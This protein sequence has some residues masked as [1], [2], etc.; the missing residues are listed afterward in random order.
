MKK[1]YLCNPKNIGMSKNLVIVESPA[2]AKTIE[3]FLGK[4]YHVLSC[5]GHI[6]DLPKNSISI[7][8][9]R[10]FKPEYV[11]PAEKKALISQ[12]SKAAKAAD[13]VWLASDEDREGEAIAWH[14]DQVL[15]L[16]PSKT[17]RIVFNEITKTAILHAIENPREL[18]YDLVDAQQARRVLD[19]LVG[20][21]IS[22]L[23]WRKV[24]P[25]LS[26]GRVQSVAV[27]LVVERE[28]EIKGFKEESSY[29]V[30]A[31]FG[32]FT[33]E[34]NTRFKSKEEARAFLESC[35]SAKFSVLDLDVKPARRSPAPPFTTSTLQQEASRKLG[36]PVAKTMMVAQQLYEEGLITYMRTDSVNLSSLAINMA[37]EQIVSVYGA[38]YSKPRNFSTKTKGAQEA[39]EAIRPTYMDRASITG[40]ASRI[41]LYDLIWKRA[42][43]SQ[44]ADAEIER[45]QINIAVSGRS[46]YFVAKGE[47]VLFDGFLK[48]YTEGKDDEEEENGEHRLPVLKK[49]EPLE[50]KRMGA[51]EI[52]SQHPPRYS[53]ASLVK[54]LEELGI[55]RPSTYAPT[56]STILKREYVVK[57]DRPGHLRKFC[58]FEMQNGKV[59]ERSLQ[60]NTGAEKAKLFPTD[61]GVL[62]NQ[63]LVRYFSDIV[64]YGFTADVEKQFDEIAQGEIKWNTMIQH[65]YGPFHHQVESTAQNSEKVSGERLLGKDPV[66][67]QPIY[68]KLGRFGP[69][70]QKGD[71]KGEDK[72]AFAGL[73]KGVSMEDVTLEQALEMFKLPRVVGKHDGKDITAAVGRFGPYLRFDGKFVSIPK[74]DDPVSISLERAVELINSKAEAERQKVIKTFAE[75]PALQVLNGRY[76][77][78][79]SFENK[80]YKIEK[81]TDASSLT[82]EDCRR[83]IAEEKPSERSARRAA[84][85]AKRGAAKT[86]T[87]S[88]SAPAAR[89]STSGKSKSTA[90][91]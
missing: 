80:N 45:T 48:V 29:K 16:E 91:K 15:K 32:G 76:G 25:N 56:I 31:S 52:F 62:V 41:R 21:E 83:I 67:G 42:V 18:D 37:K 72:P 6:R 40:D 14:L 3:K 90:K 39:H 1:N 11:I 5:F 79:I 54:K 61:T 28:E 30:T 47:V 9:E 10:D 49:G 33:A 46:E 2:K 86:A 73:K 24:R 13:F 36:F 66:S 74:T 26:A 64:D 43:A 57:E 50:L 53:E 44:M 89:K 8:T 55:G 23:L 51:R 65:F 82:I 12:L 88:S 81:G 7:D 85:I 4:D 68:V 78:Y 87:K 60:E 22:P 34:L 17:R 69:V 35:T 27:R 75:E 19:R 38:K 59:E 71:S 70:I 20:Y 77:P 63:F 84:A 58:A